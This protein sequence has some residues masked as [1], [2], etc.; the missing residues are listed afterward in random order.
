[1]AVIRQVPDLVDEVSRHEVAML[2][3]LGRDEEWEARVADVDVM[4]EEVLLEPE[5]YLL[6]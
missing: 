6:G 5:R 3:Q 2:P 1:M 4:E